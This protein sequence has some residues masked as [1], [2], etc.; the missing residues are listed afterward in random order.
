MVDRWQ[1]ERPRKALA[2][3]RT[4]T[5]SLWLGSSLESLPPN[6]LTYCAAGVSLLGLFSSPECPSGF[7]IFVPLIFEAAFY[8]FS[9]LKGLVVGERAAK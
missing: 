6:S 1:G 3:S 4:L 2:H 9:P 7:P 8:F 5:H